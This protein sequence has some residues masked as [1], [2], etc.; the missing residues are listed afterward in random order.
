MNSTELQFHTFKLCQNY[1]QVPQMK[2][3]NIILWRKRKKLGGVVMKER[4]LE[5]NEFSVMRASH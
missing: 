1:R 4:P 2:E 3:G 5:K